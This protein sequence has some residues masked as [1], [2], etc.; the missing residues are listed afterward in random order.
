MC[1]R[2]WDYEK[3]QKA[4]WQLS[5]VKKTFQSAIMLRTYINFAVV[6]SVLLPF[7]LLYFVRWMDIYTDKKR[8]L[9]SR[10]LDSQIPSLSKSSQNFLSHKNRCGIK[11]H[12]TCWYTCKSQTQNQQFCC[13]VIKTKQVIHL[14]I[15]KAHL[16]LVGG[17]QVWNKSYK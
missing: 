17:G 6:L 8:V 15:S 12:C 13:T 11:L 1:V 2:R 10:M 7:L 4:R 9:L 3:I 16:Q 5:T 14:K